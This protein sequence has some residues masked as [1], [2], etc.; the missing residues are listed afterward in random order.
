MMIMTGYKKEYKMY[1]H[2][3]PKVGTQSVELHGPPN[4]GG[5]SSFPY[6]ERGHILT[7]GTQPHSP[8]TPQKSS[9]FD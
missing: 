8:G 9:F 3:T 1:P 7:K 2:P 5:Q 4:Y 6:M